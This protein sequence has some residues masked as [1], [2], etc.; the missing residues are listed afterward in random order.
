AGII[1]DPTN[2]SIV[3]AAQGTRRLYKIDAPVSA[4][5]TIQLAAGI[6]PSLARG[7]GGPATAT[8]VNQAIPAI[9][10]DDTIYISERNISR[11]RAVDPVTGLIRTVTG[12]G[13]DG[14]T[15]IPGAAKDAFN[16]GVFFGL[17]T[18]QNGN[19]YLPM[20]DFGVVAKV[21]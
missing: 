15:G 9:A 16:G 5:Q 19:L 17:D 7:D 18:D 1:F 20:K 21:T 2:G 6:P 14:V 3:F 8:G 12:Q 13:V 11:T 10:P 4:T